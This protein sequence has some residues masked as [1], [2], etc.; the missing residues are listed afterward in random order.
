MIAKEYKLTPGQQKA[1]DAILN[2]ENVFL[3]GAAGSGKSFVVQQILALKR[4]QVLACAPTARAAIVI[5]G[6]T[7]HSTF[8]L[9]PG[10]IVN[11]EKL[12]IPNVVAACDMVLI[13]EIS[14]VRRDVFDA[15]T[16]IIQKENQARA[17]GTKEKNTPIQFV[18]VG[19]F[20]Q[21]PPVVGASERE[22]LAIHYGVNESTISKNTF[23]F[24][25]ENWEK[26]RFSVHYLTEIV[27][28][29][30]YKFVS[31]LNQARVGDPKCV[32]WINQH[33]NK[34]CPDG[35]IIIQGRNRDVDAYNNR[36]LNEIHEEEKEY[37]GEIEGE[38]GDGKSNALP[39]PFKLR[40][41]KGAR[42]M[43]TYNSPLFLNGE[44]GTIISL[45]KNS[46]LV[47][48][49][50]GKTAYIEP[51]TWTYY[52]YGVKRTT[53]NHKLVSKEVGH[54]TQIPLRLGWAVSIHKSQ[55]QT[56]DSVM[57]NPTTWE[58]GMLYVALSRVRSVDNLC[59]IKPIN[60]S[61]LLTSKEVVDFYSTIPE[62]PHFGGDVFSVFS[63]EKPM[64]S[65][66]PESDEINKNNPIFQKGVVFT[67]Q[68]DDG[69]SRDELRQLVANLGGKPQATASGK[70]DIVVQ[71]N[72][73]YKNQIDTVKTLKAKE[74][75][76][77]GVRETIIISEDEWK[78]LIADWI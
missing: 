48:T 47:A 13:D 41:K 68:F 78:D 24:Q 70:T 17:R 56:Y 64:K 39:S 37:S 30:D 52:N 59:L 9:R 15:I 74:N 43:S 28:Q 57:L 53:V 60:K 77:V 65:F 55:G 61:G 1:F 62:A 31:A 26:C 54:F 51:I 11:P 45:N 18:C 50:R 58:A 5:N 27:R 71:G 49:D 22:V 42:V 44:L 35:A 29:K 25:S 46:V 7:I 63:H 66:I 38:C 76:I 40:L 4:G 33:S 2:H 75:R 14:M 69:T 67:G 36:K 10:P 23:A 32:D 16:T 20:S 8:G 73:D 3:T 21:L 19:D 72:A 6:A 34:V 12:K